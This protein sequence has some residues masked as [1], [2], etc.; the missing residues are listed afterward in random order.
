MGIIL[1]ILL[2]FIYCVVLPQLLRKYA[3]VNPHIAKWGM[4][5]IANLAYDNNSNSVILG[6]E[7]A[8]DGMPFLTL[9]DHQ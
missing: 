2:S 6:E 8:C 1:T 3:H 7:G 9:Q 4:D 5:S